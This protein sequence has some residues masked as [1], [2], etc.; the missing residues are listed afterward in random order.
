MHGH[1]V[2]ADISGYTRFLTDNELEHA[3]GIIGELLNTVIGGDPRRRSRCPSI[4]GDAVFMYGT[5]PEGMSGQT[6][7]Q[8]VENLYCAF[9]GSL[10]TMVL[11]TTCRCNACAN[12]NGLGLKIVM[13]CGEFI[14]VGYRWPRDPV[15]AGRHPGAPAAQE[16]HPRDHRDRR[17]HVRQPG[18]RR[19]P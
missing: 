11:N 12:I 19:R 13:H 18:L 2:I 9:A 15:G 3:N 17:L 5:R 16:H 8:S 1:L 14:A 10:E 7:L 4:E 6:V